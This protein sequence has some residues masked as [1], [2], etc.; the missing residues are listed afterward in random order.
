MACGRQTAFFHMMD[1]LG[2]IEVGFYGVLLLHFFSSDTYYKHAV[3]D[4]IWL[5]RYDFAKLVMCLISKEEYIFKIKPFA[6]IALQNHQH[7]SARPQADPQC[8]EYPSLPSSSVLER[9]IILSRSHGSDIR[10]IYSDLR[11]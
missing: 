1:G 5:M 10:C 2:E 4:F 6:E 8:F 9:A 11:E 3:Y 7:G